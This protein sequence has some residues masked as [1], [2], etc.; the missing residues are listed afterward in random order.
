MTVKVDDKA[1]AKILEQNVKTVHCFL[2]VCHSWAGQS[3]QPT[4]YVGSPEQM[5]KFDKYEDNE[6]SVYVQKGLDIPSDELLI[7]TSTFLWFE[8]LVVVGM[9]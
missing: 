5:D 1:K 3:I 9:I 2:H 4:V 8:R 6:I 7:T